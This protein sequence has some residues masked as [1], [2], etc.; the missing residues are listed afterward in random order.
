MSTN[1]HYD[2]S[3]RPPHT[4]LIG[5]DTKYAQAPRGQHCQTNT[6]PLPFYM[7]PATHTAPLPVLAAPTELVDTHCHLDMN[8]YAT[9]LDEV[10]QS[11]TRHGVKRIITIGVNPPSSQA[12]VSLA[13][14]ISNIFATVGIHPHDARQ[15]TPDNLRRLADLA[16][17]RRVVGYGEIGLDYVKNYAPREVQLRAFAEQLRLAVELGLPVVIHDREAHEDVCRLIKEAGPFPRGGV[18]HCFSGNLRLAETMIDLG[19]LISIPGVVTFANAH[20]L[21]EVVRTIDLQHLLLE[22][23]GPY[24]A[25]VPCR[26]KRNEPKLLLFTAQ[27]VADLKMIPLDEVAQATTANAVRLFQ[28]TRTHHDLR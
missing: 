11:A 28:L 23:D 1:I 6:S 7:Q 12:A 25:P 2:T 18:M 10:L 4:A 14:R 5:H 8:E 13:E 15:A 17:N 16:T 21:H 24:L 20:A 19:F 27:K 3:C 22:T 26:G 9:D